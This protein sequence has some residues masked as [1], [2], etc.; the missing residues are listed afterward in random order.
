MEVR[1]NG[2]PRVKKKSEPDI[3][4]SEDRAAIRQPKRRFCEARVTESH[5]YTLIVTWEAF[6]S[7]YSE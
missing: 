3:P 5:P 1:Q 7:K 4:Q 6:L 2:L